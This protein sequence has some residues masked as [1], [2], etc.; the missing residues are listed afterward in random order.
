M[1][2][3]VHEASLNGHYFIYC[4]S[5]PNSAG[6]K[7]HTM[8]KTSKMKISARKHLLLILL[9]YNI[10]V[11]VNYWSNAFALFIEIQ[12]PTCEMYVSEEYCPPD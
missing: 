8:I 12:A 1:R 10:N 9:P 3:G 4:T 2:S 7:G 5:K 6:E 11:L